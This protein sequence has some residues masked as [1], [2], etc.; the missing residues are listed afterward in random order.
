MIFQTENQINVFLIFLF[1]GL[2]CC[3][4]FN[5]LKTLFLINF[6]KNF[7]K[8][9]FY[10][11][12]YCVFSCFFVI[13]LIFYNYGKFSFSILLEINVFASLTEVE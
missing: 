6:F 13:L 12:F 1:F 4:L 10:C 8:I 11:V 7:I 5:L 3:L 2:I 9:L